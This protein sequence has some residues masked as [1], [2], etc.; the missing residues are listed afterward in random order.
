MLNLILLTHRARSEY[1]Q[2]FAPFPIHENLP[3][4][5]N[6]CAVLTTPLLSFGEAMGH[7]HFFFSAF[8]EYSSDVAPH[9]FRVT[10]VFSCCSDEVCRREGAKIIA[11]R[12]NPKAYSDL[13][14]LAKIA[15]Q[16]GG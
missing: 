8:A 2:D 9:A 15:R 3:V 4:P 6:A 13:G 11:A 14:R 1:I 16:R 10:S 12:D 7:L 5:P